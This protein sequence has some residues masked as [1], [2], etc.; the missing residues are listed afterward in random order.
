MIVPCNGFQ[1]RQRNQNFQTLIMFV[2]FLYSFCE[3]IANSNY[4]RTLFKYPLV[5][6]FRDNKNWNDFSCWSAIIDLLTELST[7]KSQSNVLTMYATM[8]HANTSA[9]QLLYYWHY[10]FF[11]LLLLILF[12]DEFI[13]Y[14][15]NDKKCVWLFFNHA[16]FVVRNIDILGFQLSYW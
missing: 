13:S 8:L 7:I 2:W 14:I 4:S 16:V 15:E 3:S 9:T 5:H 1:A 10:Y 11:L 12:T 6:W